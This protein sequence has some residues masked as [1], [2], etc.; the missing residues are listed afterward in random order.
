MRKS[1][2][3]FFLCDGIVCVQ[4]FVS[5]ERPY[6]GT[7]VK[8]TNNTPGYTTRISVAV[9]PFAE[10]LLYCASHGSFFK[11]YSSTTDP[12]WSEMN[13]VLSSVGDMKSMFR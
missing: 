12:S 7:Y 9:G 11:T 2:T 1:N 13:C 4:K 3:V 8:K 10:L 5:S 6:R